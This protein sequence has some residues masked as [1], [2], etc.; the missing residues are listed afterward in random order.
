MKCLKEKMPSEIS[1]S[2]GGDYEDGILR[3]AVS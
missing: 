2:H 1:G 3:R